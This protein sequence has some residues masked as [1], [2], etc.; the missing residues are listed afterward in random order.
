MALS[1]SSVCRQVCIY[2][3]FLCQ[4][5]TFSCLYTRFCRP[6]CKI[7]DLPYFKLQL[8][9][10]NYTVSVPKCKLTVI[11]IHKKLPALII[12]IH[13]LIALACRF[14]EFAVN[15]FTFC[16]R[17]VFETNAFFLSYTNKWT[18]NLRMSTVSGYNINRWQWWDCKL[19]K[20]ISYKLY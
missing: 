12:I 11:V 2:L 14:A 15:W 8:H 9:R 7:K 6:N 17:L 10:V 5:L 3:P 1:I 16:D 18:L 13:H 4:G 19:L 20:I